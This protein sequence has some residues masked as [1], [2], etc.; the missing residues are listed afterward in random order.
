MWILRAMDV[1]HTAL[2]AALIFGAALLYSTVGHG[3]AS[4]YLAAMA[5][6]GIAPAV[7]RPTALTLNLA[8]A[9]IGAIKFARAG[10][11]SWRLFWPFALTSIPAAYL[12]GR[13]I[14][15]SPVYKVVVGVVLLYAAVQLFRTAG[16]TVAAVTTPP[17]WAALGVGAVIGLLSGLTGVG[18]GIF[19]SPLLL[20]MGWAE[21]RTAS[22]VAALFILVNSAAGLLGNR[23]SVAHV[24]TAVSFL[25]PAAVIGGLIGAEY[26]SRRLPPPVLRKW[27]AAVL[28]VAGSKLIVS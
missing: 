26:G 10:W 27:L 20:M 23:A 22:G 3:G 6:L 28:V 17:L 16:R 5:L 11:F 13:M 4:A 8:V 19:L 14:L 18:G 12:G 24:S 9:A 21:T 25:L 1:T 15:P 7:M 2:L